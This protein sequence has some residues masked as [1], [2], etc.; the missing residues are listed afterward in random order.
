MKPDEFKKLAVVSI[1]S[2]A[3]LGYVDDLLFDTS[4]LR[5]AGFRVKADGHHSLVPIGEVKSIGS[6]AVTVS[7]DAAARSAQAESALAALPDVDRLHQ[8]KVVD[9]AGTYLGKV[10][11]LEVDPQTGSIMGF[12]AHE[13]GVLGLGGRTTPIPAADVRSVGDEIIVVAAPGTDAAPGATP[14]NRTPPS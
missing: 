8:L 3:K 6:D 7:D 1:Q 14:G 12:E 11:S 4:H 5:L 9:E 13:G 10:S 2:G